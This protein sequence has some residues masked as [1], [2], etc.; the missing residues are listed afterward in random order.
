MKRLSGPLP[1]SPAVTCSSRRITPFLSAIA[2]DGVLASWMMSGLV[3]W[4]RSCVHPSSGHSTARLS[5]PNARR[6]HECIGCR[7]MARSSERDV[8]P[9]RPIR[10]RRLRLE[11]A[12]DPGRTAEVVC[13]WIDARKFCGLPQVAAGD[14]EAEPVRSECP[15]HGGGEL[16]GR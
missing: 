10:G 13:L 16:I 1:P 11:V 7:V 5:R 9:E 15:G 4:S 12:H 3:T 14:G 6:I 8:Q 2:P